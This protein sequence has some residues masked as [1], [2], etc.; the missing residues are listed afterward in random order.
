MILDGHAHL[1][2]KDRHV[3]LRVRTIEDTMSAMDACSVDAVAI[4]HLESLYYDFRSGNDKLR[5][6]VT[7][8]PDR[9]IP[10]F[11]VHPRYGKE[12]LAEIDRCAGDWGWRGL[13][14]HPQF[15]LYPANSKAVFE[16]VGRASEYGCVVLFHSGDSYVG[17][18][19]SPSMV[20]DVAAKFPATDIIMGH[21]GVTD[22][23]E[24]IELAEDIGNI[25][26]DATGC[27][28]NYGMLEFAAERVGPERVIWGSDIP[29]YPVELGLSKVLDSDLDV[30]AKRLILGEN[31]A[32]LM[33]WKP[34]A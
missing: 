4:S 5:E 31:F 2:T 18:Y 14:L 6:A 3:P 27:T 22:W 15:Q 28:I 16:V 24:A 23:P 20:A 10:F 25:I 32:R 26:L 13:K 17:S 7:R 34:A 21:M 29:L 1:G 12:A 19:A 30:T 11:N 8:Y 9:I 33:N